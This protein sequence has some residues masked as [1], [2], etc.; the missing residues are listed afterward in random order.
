MSAQPA[1]EMSRE[2]ELLAAAVTKPG[3]YTLKSTSTNRNMEIINI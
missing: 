2:Q 1:A 3:E